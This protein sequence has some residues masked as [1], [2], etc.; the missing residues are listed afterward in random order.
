MSSYDSKALNDKEFGALCADLIPA[1]ADLVLCLG[2][3]ATQTIDGR[4]AD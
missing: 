3:D 4:R 1:I 2:H